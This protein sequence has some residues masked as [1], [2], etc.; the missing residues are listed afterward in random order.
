VAA[1][2]QPDLPSV[3]WWDRRLRG[4]KRLLT[5]LARE[6]GELLFDLERV[7]SPADAD[8]LSR[9]LGGVTLHDMAWM[10][11]EPWRRELARVFDDPAMRAMLDRVRTVRVEVGGDAS[12]VPACAVL[13]LGWLCAQL[14]WSVEAPLAGEGGR[15][16]ARARGPNGEIRF[17]VAVTPIDRDESPR[18]RA[19]E[20]DLGDDS[21]V[22]LRR[23]DSGWAIAT[24]VAAG[25]RC[26]LPR[27]S[28][29]AALTTHEAIGAAMETGGPTDPIYLRALK[30]AVELAEA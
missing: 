26:P 1:L 2:V 29:G 24:R 30:R 21:R 5:R 28:P 17:E 8:A 4:C 14:G 3:L 7:G 10:R 23:E 12:T 11:L 25:D 22:E 19:I 15:R 13:Y 9:T 16:E 20:L 27:A 18:P 6:L